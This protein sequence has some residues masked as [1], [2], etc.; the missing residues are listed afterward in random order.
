MKKLK[1]FFIFLLVFVTTITKVQAQDYLINFAG[2]GASTAVDSVLVQNLTEGTSLTLNG[3][4]ILHLTGTVGIKTTT[5]NDNSLQ[6]YPNPVTTDC[7]V[8]FETVKAGIVRLDLFD[9]TG[10]KVNSFQNNLA[11]GIHT[12]IINGLSNGVYTL[13]LSTED[14]NCSSKIISNGKAVGVSTINYVNSVNAPTKN[15]TCTKETTGTTN[16]RSAS[17]TTV[18]MA[19]TTGDRILLKG[20]FDKY[21]T[22]ISIVPTASSTQTF[23][24]VA[25]TD[26]DGNNYTTVTIGT[27]VW[28]VENLK[29]TTYNDGTAIPNVTD[30]TAWAA[31]TTGAY[32]DY[33]NLAANGAKYGHLYNWYAVNT[34]KLAPAGWH[35]PTDAE[36]TTL[37]NYLIANGYNYDATTTDNKIAKPLAA[38]TDWK[39]TTTTGVIGNDLTLNNSTG[40]SALPGGYRGGTGWFNNLGDYGI[41]WSATEYSTDYAWIRY[42]S[43]RNADLFSYGD[44]EQRGF[45]VRCVRD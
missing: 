45:S 12:L 43:Y 29:V 25:A 8:E 38:T 20:M 14:G 4:D 19:Y 13:T 37:Q 16:L 5:V 15:V 36:W 33:S 28:M 31:L 35:V 40:F 22:L 17:T 11:G 42:L 18:D 1:A 32:C 27:Q 39:I 26:N 3:S 9:I 21:S 44:D 30:A 24:F 23:N 34:G 7:N 10:R 41:W 2:S 6:I